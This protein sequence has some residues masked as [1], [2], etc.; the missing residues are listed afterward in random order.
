MATVFAVNAYRSGLLADPPACLCVAVVGP[1]TFTLSGT[2]TAAG[3]A[4]TPGTGGGGGRPPYSCPSWA[5]DRDIRPGSTIGNPGKVNTP[6]D[7]DW[8]NGGTTTYTLVPGDSV[9]VCGLN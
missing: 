3:L 1:A 5:R 6:P 9:T 2:T 4:G 7:K 8:L